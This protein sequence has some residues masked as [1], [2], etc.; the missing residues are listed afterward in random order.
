MSTSIHNYICVSCQHV[1]GMN[2]STMIEKHYLLNT[3]FNTYGPWTERN[4]GITADNNQTIARF[5]DLQ[6]STTQS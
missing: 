3:G 1:M 4:N 2:G 6:P 5:V